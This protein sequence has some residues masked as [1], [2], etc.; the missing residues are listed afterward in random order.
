MKNIY[1]SK[2]ITVDYFH[3]DNHIETFWLPETEKMTEEEYK[4]KCSIG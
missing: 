4:K 1:R 3:E 2:F